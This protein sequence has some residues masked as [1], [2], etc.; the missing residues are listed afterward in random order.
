[1]KTQN[2]VAPARD[3]DGSPLVKDKPESHFRFWESCPESTPEW[4]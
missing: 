2:P 4:F 3:P 1:V